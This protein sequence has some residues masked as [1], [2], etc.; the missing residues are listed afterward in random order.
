MSAKAVRVVPHGDG[1]AVRRDGNQ[2]VTSTHATQ[3]EAA[4]AGRE[5]ARRVEAEFFLQGRD[6]RIR[7]RSSY[8]SDPFPPRG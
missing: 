5:T 6:G 4:R 7:E 3:A 8:G 1:W 2:R